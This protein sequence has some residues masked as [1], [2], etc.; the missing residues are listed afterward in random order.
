MDT[1][2]KKVT[3]TLLLM[4]G[5][6][7]PASAQNAAAGKAL[8]ATRCVICHGAD[9]SAKTPFAKKLKILDLSSPDVQKQSDEYFTTMIAKGKDKMP[10]W[11]DQLTPQQIDQLRD[12]IRE[13]GKKNLVTKAQNK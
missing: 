11:Y 10:S 7:A 13:L 8:F 12:Y 6:G 9:G 5:F 4:V 3:L 1:M 2:K